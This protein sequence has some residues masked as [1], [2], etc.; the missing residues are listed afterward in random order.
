MPRVKRP[1]KAPRQYWFGYCRK[2]TDS[3]DKQIYTLQDQAAIR[4]NSRQRL[5]RGDGLPCFVG[6]GGESL[7]NQDFAD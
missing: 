6:S 5:V 1:T 2:S 3:E 4:P 7:V